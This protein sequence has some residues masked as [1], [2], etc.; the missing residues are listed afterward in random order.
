[1][2]IEIIFTGSFSE[3]NF[4]FLKD[5]IVKSKEVRFNDPEVNLLD[6][7]NEVL[8]VIN[9]YD[10]SDLVINTDF[11]TIDKKVV[12]KVFIN[13]GRNHDKIELLLFFDL[14]DLN[15]DSVNVSLNCLKDWCK[16]FQNKFNFQYFICQPDGAE[17]NEYYFDSNGKENLYKDH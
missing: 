6:C 16:E 14:K 9:T 5:F 7:F 15:E 17:N 1:M 8:D 11:L 4:N 3:L 10:Y 13:L 2:L 12:Q